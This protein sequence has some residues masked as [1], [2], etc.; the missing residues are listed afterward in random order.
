MIIFVIK[1]HCLTPPPHPRLAG[2]ASRTLKTNC[3]LANCQKHVLSRATVFVANALASM[4]SPVFGETR[5]KASI[6]SVSRTVP[7][8]G[9]SRLQSGITIN[10][11]SLPPHPRLAG[12]AS[13]TLKTNCVL[14]NCQK[15]VLSRATVF[16]ANALASM[17]SPVF[18]ETRAKA[19]ILSVSRTV[20]Q[21]GTSRLQSGI[22]INCFSLPPHPSLRDT[23]SPRAKAFTTTS[24]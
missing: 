4:P 17:P 21:K 3:V 9:T 8:K 10:C 24:N 11:F 12:E 16:V 20:P 23:F 15:H 22:T 1:K 5:A 6:L 14:A 13:R 18:G 2:E 7:Q 19:S